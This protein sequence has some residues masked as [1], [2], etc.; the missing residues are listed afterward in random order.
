MAQKYILKRS[1]T[2]SLVIHFHSNTV[3]AKGVTPY[4]SHHRTILKIQGEINSQMPMN[5]IYMEYI[6]VIFKN[7]FIFKSEKQDSELIRP[8]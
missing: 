3:S 5:S 7:A 1:D 6:T 4:F 8:A 2:F